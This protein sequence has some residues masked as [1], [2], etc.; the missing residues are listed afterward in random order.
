MAFFGRNDIAIDLGTVNTIVRN[1]V[2]EIIFCEATCIALEDTRNFKRVV[3]IGEQ[4]KKMLGRA[5]Q[6]FE[7]VNPLLNGA[8]SDFETTKIFIG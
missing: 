6:N 2:E 1:N 8:I 4:A 7:I 5:P 3:C